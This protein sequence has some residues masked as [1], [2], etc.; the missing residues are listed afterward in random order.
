MCVNVKSDSLENF[1]APAWLV[2]VHTY[3]LR[4]SRLHGAA[5]CCAMVE[6]DES[7]NVIEPQLHGVH[8]SAQTCVVLLANWWATLA[9]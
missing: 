4:T 3:E 2:C 8:G 6:V 7:R 5:S 9:G 1:A